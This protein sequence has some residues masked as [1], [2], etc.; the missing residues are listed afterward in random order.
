V[1]WERN[2]KGHRERPS[3]EKWHDREVSGMQDG[4]RSEHLLDVNMQKGDRVFEEG[5][6]TEIMNCGGWGHRMRSAW[7]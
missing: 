2:R 6:M 3:W 1:M 5:M 4:S 7:S